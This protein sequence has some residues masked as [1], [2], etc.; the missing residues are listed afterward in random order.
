MKNKKEK[1]YQYGFDQEKELQSYLNIGIKS[2]KK[3]SR[4]EYF[5]D[6]S[7]WK[8][9]VKSI[10]PL[11]DME[12]FEHYIFKNIRD[13]KYLLQSVN[14]IVI[15]LEVAAFSIIC[16]VPKDNNFIA[17]ILSLM[18]VVALFSVFYYKIKNAICFWEDC[19]TIMFND[20]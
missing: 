4:Y 10:A 2:K 19:Y 9:H 5:K 11:D 1:N 16:G 12:N 15:P 18:A 6:Y 3:N 13:N 20:K 8:K 14:S 7:E 17:L